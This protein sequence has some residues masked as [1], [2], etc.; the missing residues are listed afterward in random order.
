VRGYNACTMALIIWLDDNPIEAETSIRAVSAAGYEVEV[1]RSELECVKA[2]E[3]G[4]VPGLIVQ[5]LQRFPSDAQISGGSSRTP[6]QDARV[7]GWRFYEDVLRPYF[8]QIPVIVYTYDCYVPANRQRADD[9]NLM[10]IA[11]G[12]TNNLLLSI[13]RMQSAQLVVH[14]SSSTAPN[15][16]A[17]DFEKV[18]DSLIRH[19]AV[20]P[21]DL[22][23]VSWA[24]FEA[25]VER[26]LKEMGYE[27]LHTPLTRDGG[28]DVWAVKRTD[29]GEVLYAI[30]AKKYSPNKILGPQPVR[31]IYAV[32]DINKASVGMI[33]TTARFGP[34]AKAMENQ[35]RYRLSLKD[36]D[37]VVEWIK[38]VGG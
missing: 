7:S 34:A 10:I 21:A 29:L 14:A 2:L 16:V 30:D 3:S 24:T 6:S 23:K 1:L 9:Y 36:Y 27:V 8:P 26:L 11:K 20:N 38:Y 32:A 15:I 33:V 28:V 13:G 5:D 12:E 4:R 31:A 25:L 35:Y 18:N 17:V 22:H 19:L 37:G